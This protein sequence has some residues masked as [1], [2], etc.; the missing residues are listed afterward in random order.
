MQRCNKLLIYY[1]CHIILL[2]VPEI[3]FRR[4]D[5]ISRI[6]KLAI[7]EKIDNIYLHIIKL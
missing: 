7:C 6:L 3:V 4:F 5:G 2:G 1:I